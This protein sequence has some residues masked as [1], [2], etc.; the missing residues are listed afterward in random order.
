MYLKLKFTEY[1]LFDEININ[2]IQHLETQNIGTGQ[3]L[4][5]KNNRP[6]QKMETMVIFD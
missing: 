5:D 1:D 3:K 4:F 2:I 6:S